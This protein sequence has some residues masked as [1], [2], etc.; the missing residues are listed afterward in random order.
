MTRRSFLLLLFTFLL[1]FAQQEAMLHPYE[2]TADWQQK[3]SSGKQ[4]PLNSGVCAKCVALI[5]IGS[6]VGSASQALLVLIGQFELL[7]TSRPSLVSAHFLSYHSRALPY[8]A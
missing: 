4:T 5:D 3:S 2:H 6:A 1:V 7:S 8:L